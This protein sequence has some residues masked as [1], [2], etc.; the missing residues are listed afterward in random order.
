[1]HRDCS[2]FVD[3]YAGGGVGGGMGG[4]ARSASQAAKSTHHDPA[5]L[6]ASACQSAG[7]SGV[8]SATRKLAFGLVVGFTSAAM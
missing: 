1:M 7:L 4:G 2:A 3:V 6:T 5:C 8:P